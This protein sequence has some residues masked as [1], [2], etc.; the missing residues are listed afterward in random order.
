MQRYC[1]L[2]ERKCDKISQESKAISITVLYPNCTLKVIIRY[3]PSAKE[4]LNITQIIYSQHIATPLV[5]RLMASEK[6][7]QKFRTQICVVLLIG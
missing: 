4:N 1:T 3:F 6:R 5:P 7:V 2:H